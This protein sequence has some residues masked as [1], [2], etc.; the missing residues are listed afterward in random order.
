MAGQKQKLKQQQTPFVT[1]N[2]RSHFESTHIFQAVNHVVAVVTCLNG[3][4]LESDHWHKTTTRTITASCKAQPFF[5][6]V[7]YLMVLWTQQALKSW[8]Y[9]YFIPLGKTDALLGWSSLISM[10][11]WGFYHPGN[12]PLGNGEAPEGQAGPPAWLLAA[13]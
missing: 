1:K 3:L 11:A 2:Q 8:Y 10:A 13:A 5:K 7:H 4:I 12:F 9:S 6:A